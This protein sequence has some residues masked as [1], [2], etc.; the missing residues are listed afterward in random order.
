M[1][2]EVSVWEVH[3]REI[4]KLKHDDDIFV[5]TTQQ[6]SHQNIEQYYHCGKPNYYT[7]DEDEYIL[8]HH[9]N[10]SYIEISNTLGRTYDSVKTRYKLLQH[11]LDEGTLPRNWLD[12]DRYDFFKYNTEKQQ[13]EPQKVVEPRLT[14]V[15]NNILS[16]KSYDKG[17]VVCIYQT[18][19]LH[20]NILEDVKTIMSCYG[21]KNRDVKDVLK[22]YHPNNKN[23]T[24]ETKPRIYQNYISMK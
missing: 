23:N 12:K 22:K 8:K 9:K 6:P 20:K 5:E 24:L 16:R 19:P 10:K 15:R 21:W 3:N 14:R 13:Q 1:K 18:L 4:T 2:I 17:N 11:Y 7:T